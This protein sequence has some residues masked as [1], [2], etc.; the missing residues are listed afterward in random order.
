MI[1]NILNK[2]ALTDYELKKV[3]EALYHAERNAHPINRREWKRVSEIVKAKLN[4]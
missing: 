1:R 3:L 2:K 4:N